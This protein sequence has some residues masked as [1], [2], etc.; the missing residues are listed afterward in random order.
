MKISVAGTGYVGLSIATLLAQHNE[1]VSV[2]IVQERIDK[3]NSRISPIQD[4]YIEAYLAGYKTKTDEDIKNWR[5]GCT[6]NIETVSLD[7]HATLDWQAGY[8]DADFV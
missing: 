6:S 2:D 8:R 4:D 1:V 3:V 5:S 7:L